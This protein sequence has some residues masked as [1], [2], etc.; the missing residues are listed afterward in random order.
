[1]KIGTVLRNI[2]TSYMFKVI[3]HLEFCIIV[4][5]KT[6]KIPERIY[7]KVY[8][9]DGDLDAYCLTKE[10]VEENFVVTEINSHQP[11]EATGEMLDKWAEKMPNVLDLSDET[12][13]SV[14][15]QIGGMIKDSE[16]KDGV[17]VIKDLELRHISLNSI[18]PIAGSRNGN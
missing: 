6:I 8:M 18:Q 15:I 13:E 9:P 12:I 10:D 3:E 16:M 17:R 1:M 7:V 11:Q 14:E 5:Q 2:N 4:G